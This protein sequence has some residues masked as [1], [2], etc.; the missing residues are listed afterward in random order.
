M[1][2]VIDMTIA[3]APHDPPSLL[4]STFQWSCSKQDYET[5]SDA[6]LI[7]W[8]KQVALSDGQVSFVITSAD[9]EESVFFLKAEQQTKIELWLLL[10]L[11]YYFLLLWDNF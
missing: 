1:G 3:D 8:V 7:K 10:R 9:F 11:L 6:G 4:P 2:E 5:E